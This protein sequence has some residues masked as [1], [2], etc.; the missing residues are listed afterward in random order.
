MLGAYPA[1]ARLGETREECYKRY[2][3]PVAE[4]PALLETAVSASFMFKGIRIRIEFLEDRAAFLSFSRPGLRQEEREVLLRANAGPLVWNPPGEFAGRMCWMA[5]A[6]AGGRARHAIAYQAV[7][8]GYLDVA[9]DDWSKA[10]RAQ[11]AVQFAI[12]PRP[13]VPPGP[14]ASVPAAPAPPAASAAQGKLDGF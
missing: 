12:R 11:Q 14:A 1:A 5:P 13:V 8:T 3:Q 4:V 9:S 2:G 7:E 6:A 10:M